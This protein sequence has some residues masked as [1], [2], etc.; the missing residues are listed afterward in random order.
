MSNKIGKWLCV[1]GCLHGQWYDQAAKL[2][3]DPYNNPLREEIYEPRRLLNPFTNKEET[4][5]LFLK[6]NK[7]KIEFAIKDAL[8][9]QS[10]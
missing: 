7:D 10:E 6:L 4:F 3:A 5:F 1:G 8:N 9:S 2:T